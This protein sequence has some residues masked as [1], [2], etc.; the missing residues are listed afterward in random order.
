MNAVML[1]KGW[2]KNG[3]AGARQA[4]ADFWYDVATQ[5]TGFDVPDPI[6]SSVT[7]W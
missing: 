7:K 3:A 1:A 5:D 4:L 6:K 2:C